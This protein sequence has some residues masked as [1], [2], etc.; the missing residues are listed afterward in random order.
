[1]S[2][3][4]DDQL[5][6]ALKVIDSAEK[7]GVNPD[8]VLPMVMVESGFKQ[9]IKSPRGAIGVMQL[10]PDTAKGLNVNPND[11]DEN[12][13]GGMRLL[14]ELSSDKRIGGDPYK[15]YVIYEKAI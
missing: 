5:K 4:S 1:M 15:E 6:I 14:K 13:D 9:D 11:L 12:I 7:H 10:M 3:L 2:K 8:F